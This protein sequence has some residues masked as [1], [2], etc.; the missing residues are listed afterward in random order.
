MVWTLEESSWD[1]SNIEGV[2]SFCLDTKGRDEVDSIVRGFVVVV[3]LDTNGPDGRM[4]C[5]L[6]P[7]KPVVDVDMLS[8]NKEVPP[9]DWGEEARLPN[10]PPGTR[11]L[12]WDNLDISSC[13]ADDDIVA[14]SSF[15][16][17]YF[18]IVC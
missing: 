9:R 14:N 10:N 7:N 8:P 18:F 15:R 17:L 11:L 3:G 13:R 4:L 2:L 12:G 1:T 16:W 6:G 5:G